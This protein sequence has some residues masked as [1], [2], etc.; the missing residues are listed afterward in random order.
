MWSHPTLLAVDSDMNH[1]WIVIN[2]YR[3]ATLLYY[4]L[5]CLFTVLILKA[6]YKYIV[7]KHGTKWRA[8][9]KLLGL[10]MEQLNMIKDEF[11][12]C[13]N[14]TAE[15]CNAVISRWLDTDTGASWEKLNDVIDSLGK[16]ASK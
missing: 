10:S 7:P 16:P 13:Y 4:A 14:K 3:Y 9:G 5:F 1:C 6:A 15:C 2:T 8:I 11:Q 12:D